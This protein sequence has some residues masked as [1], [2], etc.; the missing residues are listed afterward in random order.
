MTAATVLRDE[1]LPRP[2]ILEEAVTNHLAKRK[3]NAGITKPDVNHMIE[4]KNPS[5]VADIMTTKIITIYPHQTVADAIALI[6]IHHFHHLLVLNADQRLI[7]VLSDRD[8]LGAVARF[9]D[10][11][12]AEISQA[13]TTHPVTVSPECPLFV[14]AS[15]L[16]S[17]RINCLPVVGVNESVVGILTSTDLLKSYQRIVHTMQVKLEE[18]GFIEFSL[19]ER[20][21]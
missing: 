15:E 8:L 19:Q 3:G 21:E 10:W 13:M 18:I 9:A 4:G 20:S 7:G 12:G 11:R 2:R 16:V 17:K 6:T 1:C 14:A 5:I